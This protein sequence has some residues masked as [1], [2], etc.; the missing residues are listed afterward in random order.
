[1]NHFAGQFF[2]SACS[3]SVSW[4]LIWPLENLKNV[5]QAETKGIGNSNSEK[6]KWM[7]RER[8]V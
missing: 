1:M 6:L 2:V 8:G 3:A 4:F 5:V 7:L